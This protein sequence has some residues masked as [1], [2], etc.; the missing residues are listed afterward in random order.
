MRSAGLD[1]IKIP[2]CIAP[3][4]C[5]ILRSEAGFR[6]GRVSPAPL[7]LLRPDAQE[8]L[9]EGIKGFAFVPPLAIVVLHAFHLLAPVLP[10]RG[11][12]LSWGSPLDN[13]YCTLFGTI[14]QLASYIKVYV[15]NCTLLYTF[16]LDILYT[17]R[18]NIFE[19]VEICL[20]HTKNFSL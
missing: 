6:W 1:V 3:G 15:Y 16:S 10:H 11:F 13:Y 2:P 20:C 7:A 4:G 12:Y 19:E 14:M 8:R 17:M 5:A 9:A 18:Y